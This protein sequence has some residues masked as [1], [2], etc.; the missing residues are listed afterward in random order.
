MKN[1][2]LILLFL[3][4]M[5]ASAQIE[6]FLVLVPRPLAPT[7]SLVAREGALWRSTDG[8]I[9]HFTGGNWTVLGGSQDISGI[10]TNTSSIA[11]LESEQTTQDA[12]IALNTAKDLSDYFKKDGSVDA[13]ADFDMDGHAI[14][15]VDGLVINKDPTSGVA[16]EITQE[17]TGD[18]GYYYSR[19]D[20]GGFELAKKYPSSTN[21]ER[22]SLLPSS[23]ATGYTIGSSLSSISVTSPSMKFFSDIATSAISAQF[24]GRVIGVDA[25]STNE[26]VTLSQLNSW[27]TIGVGSINVNKIS[28]A[29]G[30]N[31]QVMT[32]VSGTAVWADAT[33]GSGGTD[34]QTAAEV[35]VV[36]SGFDGNLATTDNTVQKIAQ[37]LD[38]LATSGASH[39]VN[40]IVKTGTSDLQYGSTDFLSTTGN[41]V[42]VTKTDG[43]TQSIEL[44]DSDLV[45][46]KSL[47]IETDNGS[48]II[49]TIKDGD[50]SEFYDG[51][52]T[53]DVW[54]VTAP[55]ECSATKKVTDL[56]RVRCGVV[57]TAETGPSN[58][59]TNRLGSADGSNSTVTTNYNLSNAVISVETSEV[60]NSLANSMKIVND[61][62]SG[63]EYARFD[64]SGYG[65]AFSSGD[66]VTIS[67]YFKTASGTSFSTRLGVINGTSYT[68]GNGS[69]QL[70]ERTETYSGT[71]NNFSFY[72]NNNS[73]AVYVSEITVTIAE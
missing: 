58:I 65:Q 28:S 53:G 42:I 1:K 51:T 47:L 57:S 16:L 30:T 17:N 49:T 39:T 27:G 31:D 5:C 45:V 56:I 20:L 4:S 40:Y 44:E 29:D 63:S 43:L 41:Q 72:V 14:Y 60:H 34:D 25:V 50:D 8:F 6:D 38:D 35:T 23:D 24:F 2:I 12:A 32:I 54:T 55:S 36:A 37:K 22:F 71:N 68:A 48:T 11:T 67:C 10:T 46:G 62:T 18:D 9:Y 33:G 64:M 66:V 59:Y 19:F 61:G 73:N 21:Y 13:T 3:I 7:N 26:F 15:N 69:W 52:T 70:Y